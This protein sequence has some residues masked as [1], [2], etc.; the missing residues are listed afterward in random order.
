MDIAISTIEFTDKEGKVKCSSLNA[1]RVLANN[2]EAT[3]STR[4]A[5]GSRLE[6]DQRY[7]FNIALNY[8]YVGDDTPYS[9]QGEMSST[10]IKGGGMST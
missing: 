7:S 6:A 9:V 1:D 2:E 5:L 4:C 8:K 3:F 10:V